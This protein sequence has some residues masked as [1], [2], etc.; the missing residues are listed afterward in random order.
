MQFSEKQL[1]DLLLDNEQAL[2]DHRPFKRKQP[3][4]SVSWDLQTEVAL[5]SSRRIDLLYRTKNTRVM[6]VIEAKVIAEPSAI[7][8]ANEYWREIFFRNAKPG[9]RKF[10]TAFISLAA[11][12][13]KPDTLFFA[14][15]LGI[16]CLQIAPVNFEQVFVSEVLPA[17]R[18]LQTF[19]VHNDV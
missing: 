15:K 16:Q 19:M 12:F 17:N 4:P 18:S 3:Y 1:V 10:R 6:W 11:Q 13:Y 14:K 2:W 5:P 8:Q 9:N 7:I